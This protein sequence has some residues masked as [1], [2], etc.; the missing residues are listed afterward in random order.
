MT[1]ETSATELPL[2]GLRVLDVGT[3]IAAPVTAL[4]LGEYGADVIKVEQ[5]GVGDPNRVIQSSHA[6]P[7]SPVNYPWEMDARNKRSIALDLHHPEGRAA[8]ERLIARADVLVTNF[9]LRLRER[10]RLRWED[11]HA[12]HP[13]LVYASL[14]GFGEAGPERDQPGFDSTAYFARSGFL[15]INRY[16]DQPPH[17]SMPAAGD[18]ATAM[19]LVSAILLA[20]MRREKSG[21]GGRV[22]TSLLAAGL[23]SNGV[24]V[25]AAL[26]GA[27]LPLRPPRERPRSALGNCYRCKDGRWF[28]IALPMEERFWPGLCRVVGRPELEHDARFATT[29]ARRANAAALTAVFDAVFVAE[30]WAHWRERLRA[31]RM[32]FAPITRVTDLGEDP[33]ARAA[34]AIVESDNPEM[35]LTLAVPFRIEGVEPRRPGRAP[36]LGEHSSEILREAGFAPDEIARL[37]TAG[38][39]GGV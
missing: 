23:W 11:L 24:A 32:I 39:V 16:E 34:Q 30:D 3:Y 4:V 5:P 7:K 18:R 37:R 8:M 9:P 38:V 15:D 27:T 10:M 19:S 35:P 22:S 1:S 20:L 21:R 25:Q 2:A 12:A 26:V 17:F 6:Y 28:S 36:A 29:P 13:R 14:T 31:E 33:Q